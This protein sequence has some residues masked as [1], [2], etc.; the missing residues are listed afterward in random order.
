MRVNISGIDKFADND[1]KAIPEIIRISK[2]YM[3]SDPDAAKMRMTVVVI[4][5]E[6]KG[7]RNSIPGSM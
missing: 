4:L 3:D 1:Y 2:E 5:L 6:A 7:R